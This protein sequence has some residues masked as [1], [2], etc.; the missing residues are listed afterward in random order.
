[1]KSSTALAERPSRARAEVAENYGDLEIS[2]T[3]DVLWCTLKQDARRSVTMS[4]LK[5]IREI[6]EK[7]LQG[8]WGP[9]NF[10]ILSSRLP[11]I[12]SL[13]GDLRF[14]LNCLEAGDRTSLTEY[15]L[16]SIRAVWSNASGLAPRQIN[17]VAVLQG[18][19]QGGG[20]EAALSCDMIIAERGGFC[21]FPESLFGMFPGMGAET[22]LKSRVGLEVAQKIIR[23]ANRYPAEFLFEIGVVDRLVPKGTAHLLARRVASGQEPFDFEGRRERR[24]DTLNLNELVEGVERWVEQAFALSKKNVRA[25]S[26]IVAA[27]ETNVTVAA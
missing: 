9:V 11:G 14:F 1:M 22:L 7:L 17:T 6:D 5:S 16:L 27:Q 2:V 8:T 3:D 10:K 12:F 13:G 19:A 15:A 24:L 21:G 26:Y 25:M 20:F 23:S 18:E 4:Q